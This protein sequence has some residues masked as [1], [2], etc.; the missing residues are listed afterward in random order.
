[1]NRC[2]SG[3]IVHAFL[4]FQPDYEGHY[5]TYEGEQAPKRHGQGWLLEVRRVF[6][7]SKVAQIEV[8]HVIIAL[9]CFD[10]RL[11]QRIV[12]DEPFKAC[13]HRIAELEALL[14]RFGRAL[15]RR[16]HD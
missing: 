7:R 12:E 3:G 16:V 6:D 5:D 13:F 10:R 9:S 8:E 2:Q 1:M 14:T 11:Y 15:Y 4:Q